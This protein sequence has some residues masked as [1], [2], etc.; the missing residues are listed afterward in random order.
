MRK[1]LL[2]LLILLILPQLTSAITLPERKVFLGAW[3]ILDTGGPEG[4]LPG[5]IS[6]LDAYYAS[7]PHIF[8]RILVFENGTRRLLDVHKFEFDHR[9]TAHQFYPHHTRVRIWAEAKIPKLEVNLSPGKYRVEVWHIEIPKPTAIRYPHLNVTD[10]VDWY[11]AVRLEG[12]KEC[13]R[14]VGWVCWKEY[15]IGRVNVTEKAKLYEVYKIKVVH[16]K[17][18]RETKDPFNSKSGKKKKF[19]W[20][21]PGL[22]ISL[23]ILSTAHAIVIRKAY[24]QNTKVVRRIRARYFAWLRMLYW[25]KFWAKIRKAQ[26]AL[27]RKYERVLKVEI[28]NWHRLYTFE[29][30]LKVLEEMKRKYIGNV[31]KRFERKIYA[32]ERKLFGVPRKDV[33]KRRRLERVLLFE[34]TNWYRLYTNEQKRKALESMKRKYIGKVRKKFEEM[35]YK[36]ERILRRKDLKDAF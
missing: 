33:L 7:H 14:K 34:I 26:A 25:A 28:S 29:Q 5:F 31:R 30:K 10:S 23:T 15:L 18:N 20:F 35:I 17:V 11:E 8:Y 13:T 1:F 6:S 16:S 19:S 36:L 21:V 24:I 27:R 32:L 9:G 4:E 3:E 22:F 12:G 2:L